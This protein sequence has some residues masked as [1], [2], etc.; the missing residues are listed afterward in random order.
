MECPFQHTPGEAVAPPSYLPA[1]AVRLTRFADLTEVHRNPSF[2]VAAWE[3]TRPFTDRSLFM[4]PEESEHIARRRE[5]NKIASPAALAFHRQEVLIPLMQETL[6][7]LSRHPD[8]DGVY[9]ADLVPMM[10]RV[11]V[12]FVGAMIGTRRA[13]TPAGADELL[14]IF[15][16]LQNGYFVKYFPSPEAK[17]AG[18]M[19]GVAARQAFVESFY[20]ESEQEWR[21]RCRRQQR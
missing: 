6:E 3:S 9:R 14:S 18:T 20:E 4:I 8:E 2:A 1:D 16:Q 13:L 17:R 19:A 15:S 21:A 10:Q 11:F 7:E 5:I 12:G